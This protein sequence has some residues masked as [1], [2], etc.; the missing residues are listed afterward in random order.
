M[1][2]GAPI[3]GGRARRRLLIEAWRFVPHSYAL[4]AQAYCLSL[5]QRD[6]VEL[7]FTDLPYYQTWRRTQGLLPAGEESALAALRGPEPYFAPE[8][9]FTLRPESPDFSAPPSGRRFAFGTA[10]YRVLRQ[11]NRS[12]LRS[13]AEV[14]DTVSV[15]TPSRWPALA[16][17]R[18][19][20][21]GERIHIVPL[22]VDPAVFRPDAAARRATRE[23]L[24]LQDAFIYL[25]V[26]AMTWNKGLDVLLAAFAHI[27]ETERDAVLFLKGADA[28]YDSEDL[29]RRVLGTLSPSARA[30]VAAKLVYEGGTYPS[31]SMADLLRAADVYVS[32]Y[33]AEGFNMP[34]LEAA[35]CGT[36]VICTAGGPTDE[37]TE[38]PFARRIRSLP[39]QV[40]YDGG[41]IGDYLAPDADHLVELM[42]QAAHGR[43]DAARI[44]AMGAEYV[45]RNFSWRRVT[46]R[47]ADVLFAGATSAQRDSARKT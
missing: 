10:E 23:A 42:R 25:S 32:P 46:D 18:F 26:G 16:Y 24:G 30:A 20:I 47:L 9:T 12:G 7:R 33:R 36:P 21:P 3:D 39:R 15:V 35:A 4:A 40:S 2:S 17:E 19:G 28:I 38:E 6:D 5:L 31:A 41:D 43:D 45:A 1:S 44:G 37:F 27:V 14:A 29:V 13:A 22:G 11:Q 34:V 8:A